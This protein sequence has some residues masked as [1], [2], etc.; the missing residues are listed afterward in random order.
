MVI[1]DIGQ[2]EIHKLNV[3][4]ITCWKF[5]SGMNVRSGQ[6]KHGNQDPSEHEKRNYAET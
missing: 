6:C 1:D 4:Y 3:K 2:Y 5:S